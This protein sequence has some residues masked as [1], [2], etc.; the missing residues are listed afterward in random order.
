MHMTI[1][2]IDYA[3]GRPSVASM[4]AAG[5]KF[6]ARY[7]SHDTSGKNLSR[8]EADRLAKAG[9]WCV[10]VWETTASRAK[11][12]GRAGGAADAKAA[13]SQAALCGMPG[14]RPIYF[15][16]DFDA[17]KA[18][19]PKITEYFKGV[20]SVLDLGRVGMY[21]G[22][23]PIRWGFDDHLITWGWQTY[24]WSGGRRDQRIHLYQ[25]LNDQ[26]VGG[27]DCD[28][29]LAYKTDYGQWKPGVLPTVP[30]EPPAY[31]PFPGRIITQPP[32]MRGADVK[33]W[34]TQMK[35]RGWRV[36][37]D[38]AF[39]S[40]SERVLRAFQD[41]KG[42]MVDGVLGPLSWRAAWTAPR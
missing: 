27:V 9:I 11:T 5:V 20:I 36:D 10:V 4:M 8:S 13:Q 33:V 32:I 23:D 7:L 16:V 35:K 18:D 29:D 26:R 42:M 39:G 3:W 40:G 6:A 31:P 22:Y 21:G 15:A 34:Q 24:A 30:V 14:S 17:Q 1:F 12:G 28:Y 38:G 41:E 37:A 25:Y 19:W 2:G